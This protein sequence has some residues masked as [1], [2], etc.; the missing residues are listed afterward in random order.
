MAAAKRSCSVG[1][2]QKVNSHVASAGL[3]RS[4]LNATPNSALALNRSCRR[5][6]TPQEERR[7]LRD[8]RA[9][10]GRRSRRG[11]PIYMPAN[12]HQKLR[13]RGHLHGAEKATY[14]YRVAFR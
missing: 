4:E 1:E 13:F 10:H 14:V 8:Y 3:S 5:S 6:P 9:F 12:R 2:P 11:K 7:G